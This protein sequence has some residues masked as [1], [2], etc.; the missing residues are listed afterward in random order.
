LGFVCERCKEEK[1]EEKLDDLGEGLWIV[2]ED[3]DDGEVGIGNWVLQRAASVRR[4]D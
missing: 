1:R 2:R 3:I 4:N